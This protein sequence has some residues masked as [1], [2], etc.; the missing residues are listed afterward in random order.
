MQGLNEWL[1]GDVYD[2]QSE[3]RGVVACVEQ[4]SQDI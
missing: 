4:L 3:L 2:R 1:E